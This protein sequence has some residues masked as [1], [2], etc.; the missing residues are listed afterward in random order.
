MRRSLRFISILTLG[1]LLTITSSVYASTTTNQATRIS[2]NNRYETA[3]QIANAFATQSNIDFSKGQLFE[4]V[5]LASGNNYPDALAGAPLATTMKAPILLVDK[6]PESSQVTLSYISSHV[7]KAGKV[8][9]LGGTGVIP[10]SFKTAIVKLGFKEEN[11]LQYGGANRDETSLIIAKALPNS[12]DAVTI[13]S[14]S[15]FYDALT[16]ASASAS[17]PA[18][19]PI[20]LVSNSG[21]TSSQKSYVDGLPTGSTIVILGDIYNT[22]MGKALMS[23]YPNAIAFSGKDRYATNAIWNITMMQNKPTPVVYLATGENYPDALAGAVLASYASNDYPCGLI[24]LT[25]PNELSEDA[26]TYLNGVAYASKSSSS[27][28][29]PINTNQ[30][31]VFG[32][33]GAVSNEVVSQVQQ[34]LNGAGAEAT[35]E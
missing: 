33:T 3:I 18:P 13:V 29:T 6:S 4:N 17:Q 32:G 21:L 34:I 22:D 25:K 31:V 5:V 10:V 11:I 7:N 27:G 8:I 30:I 9:L 28:L 19:S 23:T 1:L 35:T 24:V 2:G 15:N 20:L 26:K 14:D 12:V 16:G